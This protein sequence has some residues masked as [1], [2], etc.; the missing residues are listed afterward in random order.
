[1]IAHI[2]P[3]GVRLFVLTITFLILV[4]FF[5]S[6]RGLVKP[7][8]VSKVSLDDWLM[9]AAVVCE[10]P[11]LYF[12][13]TSTLTPHHSLFTRHIPPS[14]YGG[15]STRAKRET[16]ISSEGRALRFTHGSWARP[17]MLPCRPSFALPL[18]SSSF[19][20]PQTRHIDG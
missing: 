19:V 20:S 10:P 17:S 2:D 11:S 3:R 9:L 6:L 13:P 5:M 16:R 7:L 14:H 1:M 12:H 8:T 18:L 4:W 15:L